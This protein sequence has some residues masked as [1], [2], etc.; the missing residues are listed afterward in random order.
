M[1]FSLLLR[2]NQ[3]TGRF[4]FVAPVALDRQ[5]TCGGNAARNIIIII[6]MK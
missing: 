3:L 1:S 4:F 2:I 5:R 6:I